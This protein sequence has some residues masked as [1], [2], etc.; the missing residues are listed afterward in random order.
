MDELSAYFWENADKE[1]E[2][3]DRINELAKK[4]KD[5]S[6]IQ[7]LIKYIIDIRDYCDSAV[8]DAM[9]DDL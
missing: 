4:Y 7:F 5:N 9:G 1:K 3:L 8:C 2:S 6:D